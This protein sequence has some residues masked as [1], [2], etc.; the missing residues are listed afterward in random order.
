[1]C[2]IHSLF[3]LHVQK[4]RS[5]ITRSGRWTSTVH[6]REE[7]GR[8]GRGG[9]RGRRGRGRGGGERGEKEKEKK[10]TTTTMTLVTV[11]FMKLSFSSEYLKQNPL[12]LDPVAGSLF[13]M[14]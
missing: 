12:S 4:Y 14:T 3:L 11:I 2:S 10:K 8:E 5:E 13:Y 7:G 6:Q 1:M 9:G